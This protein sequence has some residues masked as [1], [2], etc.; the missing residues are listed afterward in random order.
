M[1]VVTDVVAEIDTFGVGVIS[2]AFNYL[3]PALSSVTL[4][5]GT[6]GICLIAYNQFFS[7]KFPAG[8]YMKWAFRYT[9]IT[10]GL[11]TWANFQP[12][13][14]ALDNL[15]DQYSAGII[16]AVNVN[17]G[18]TAT[19]TEEAMDDF[20]EE[21]MDT[22]NDLF[23]TKVRRLRHLGKA[24]RNL[25]LG[26]LVMIVGGF[27]AGVCIVIVVVAKVGFIAA[28]CLAPLALTALLLPATAGY[29]KSWVAFTVGF[30]LIPILSAT[31]MAI[32][33]AVA[34]EIRGS[35]SG[36]SDIFQFLLLIIGLTFMTMMLPT[37]ANSL[38]MTSVAAVGGSQAAGVITGAPKAAQS[39]GRAMIAGGQAA[40]A[41][42]SAAGKG[43][44]DGAWAG[45]RA[46]EFVGSAPG[47]KSFG[48][49]HLGAAVGGVAGA[50]LGAA[51]YAMSSITGSMLQSASTRQQR[52][53]GFTQ[54]MGAAQPSSKS[55]S[56]PLV[57][58]GNNSSGGSG[59]NSLSP[60]QM[61][62]NKNR[63]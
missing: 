9:V 1:G 11:A 14:D 59:S 63:V 26:V 51:S 52:T 25:F 62:A 35:G 54:K 29:F 58:S 23:R 45:S 33:L 61:N 41:A 40:G 6:I 60:E 46:G 37:M 13:Y 44:S 12:I 42:A 34:N 36:L 5:A 4:L 19:T 39:A 18:G 43:F 50:T 31:L 21:I 27:Y 49:N 56:S 28:M 3:T 16:N 57:V 17:G 48:G 10:T 7:G 55:S 22:A 15:Q 24:I 8:E 47:L 32:G 30:I 2:S 38:A 20:I 53:D